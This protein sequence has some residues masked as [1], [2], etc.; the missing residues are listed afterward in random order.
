MN[1]LEWGCGECGIGFVKG[2]ARAVYIMV[3]L[4]MLF[5]SRLCHSLGCAKDSKVPVRL[6]L[7][8][9]EPWSLGRASV[10]Q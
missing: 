2:N 8:P 9:R 4:L 6:E 5:D 10:S 3:L 1:A 7:S